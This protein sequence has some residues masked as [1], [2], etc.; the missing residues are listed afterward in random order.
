MRTLLTLAFVTF[1]CTPINGGWSQWTGCSA[2]CGGGSQTRTCTNPVPDLGGQPCLGSADQSCNTDR[3]LPD[4]K[5]TVHKGESFDVFQMVPQDFT[6][7][8]SDPAQVMNPVP[9]G[10]IVQ[11][12]QVAATCYE[13]T[14]PIDSSHSSHYYHSCIVSVCCPLCCPLCCRSVVLFVVVNIDSLSNKLL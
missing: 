2:L 12:N 9:G 7:D 10:G 8:S 6:A 5:L 1:G 4:L 13:Y 11:Y 14:R 3:C